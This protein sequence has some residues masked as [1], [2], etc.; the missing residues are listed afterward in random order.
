VNQLDQLQKDWND[1]AEV[2][3]MWA[4]CSEFGKSHGKWRVDEFFDTGKDKIKEALS[5]V[6]S[7]GVSLSRGVVMDFGCGVG[8]LTQAL[9][10]EFDTCY[11]VDVSPKMVELAEQF[12]RFGDRCKYI[13]NSRSDLSIFD[14][15]FFDFIYTHIVLQHMPPELMKGYL[16]EF[17][18]TLKVGGILVFQVPI[19]KLEQDEGTIQLKKLPRY[20]PRRILNKL[21]GVLIGHDAST[22]YYRLRRLGLPKTWLY[23]RL[24]FRP[25]IQMFW[26]EE[27]EIYELMA[28]AGVGA[29]VVHVVKTIE[30]GMLNGT[31]VVKKLG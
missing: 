19:Q 7:T 11:G 4:I 12:N 1:L 6:D 9:A 31:Y 10:E 29:E 22:R 24:K 26:I 30:T 25:A 13:L 23:S 2:D 20:H 14:A 17:I 8:R 16:R 15:N 5:I 27:T 3:P 18:R 28:N 21:R